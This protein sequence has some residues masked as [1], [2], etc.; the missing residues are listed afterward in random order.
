MGS[1]DSRLVYRTCIIP[2]I[3]TAIQSRLLHISVLPRNCF[4]ATFI[5]VLDDGRSSTSSS[6][7]LALTRTPLERPAVLILVSKRR[8]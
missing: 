4:V 1:P 2:T 3:Y 5:A 8:Q 7:I 6:S